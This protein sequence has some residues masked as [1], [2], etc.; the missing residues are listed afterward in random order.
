MFGAAARGRTAVKATSVEDALG[1]L[2]RNYLR[3][4]LLLLLA[5]GPSHGY[6]L[7]EKISGLGFA[8]PDAGGLYR[9]LRTMD[10]EG[11]VRSW[12]DPS[13]SGP[14]RR[15]YTLTDAGHERLRAWAG[16]VRE[17]HELLGH[18]L[19]RYESVRRNTPAAV[20]K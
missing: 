5:E 19:K 1:G 6:D 8:R 7:L 13:D 17:V 16:A 9:S 4:C 11:L 15:S 3:P 18:Y 12:W 20:P 10:Q 14:A 2:P